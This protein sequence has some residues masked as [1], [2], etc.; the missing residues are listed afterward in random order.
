MT[1]TT[2]LSLL[3]P[4]IGILRVTA[5]PMATTKTAKK[6]KG[7]L[8]LTHYPSHTM[9]QFNKALKDSE[10][11]PEIRKVCLPFFYLFTPLTNF[12]F[13][14]LEAKNQSSQSWALFNY[15]QPECSHCDC[16]MK[17]QCM[18]LSHAY[19]HLYLMNH[20]RQETYAMTQN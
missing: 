3:M 18:S 9:D 1:L 12:F 11:D 5:A 4:L 7:S 2:H 13:M 19:F 20:L 17:C 16:L 10:L 6:G 14:M 8:C 15:H